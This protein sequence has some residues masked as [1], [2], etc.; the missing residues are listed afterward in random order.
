MPLDG[1]KLRDNVDKI[2]IIFIF[3]SIKN[4]FAGENYKYVKK[5]SQINKNNQKNWK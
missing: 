1:D 5:T 2:R 4:D 3:D